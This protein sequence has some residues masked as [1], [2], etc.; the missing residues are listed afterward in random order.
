VCDALC[1]SSYTRH[2]PPASTPLA[3][4]A[5]GRVWLMLADSVVPSEDEHQVGDN[6]PRTSRDALQGVGIQR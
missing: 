1:R 3:D 2:L 5:Y 4:D 6:P